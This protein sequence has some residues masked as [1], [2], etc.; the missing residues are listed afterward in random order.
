MS[1]SS[2]SESTSSSRVIFCDR[3]NPMMHANRIWKSV[4]REVINCLIRLRCWIVRLLMPSEVSV[5]KKGVCASL[6]WK[7]VRPWGKQLGKPL[8]LWCIR[9]N[10]IL[11]GSRLL[12]GAW[13]RRLARDSECYPPPT[14][15][16]FSPKICGIPSACRLKVPVP[17]EHMD[18]VLI[19]MMMN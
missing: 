6:I 18:R 17:P 10:E 5:L 4:S 2:S 19:L 12:G 14:R 3:L 1:F 7:W 8:P 11:G 9:G 16:P 13:A 15:A